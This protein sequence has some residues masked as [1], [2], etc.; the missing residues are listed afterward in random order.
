MKLSEIK[1]EAALDVLADLMDPL[2]AILA[3]PNVKEVVEGKKPKLIIA[4]S[5]IKDHKKEI[6]EIFAILNQKT[7]EE[8][9]ES[10]T[11]TSL[12]VETL[13]LLNDKELNDFLDLQTGTK[14]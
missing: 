10:M 9:M 5:L 1:G 3:D 2:T 4:K 13:D 11:I 8:Y 12:I 7:P 14:E 6:V